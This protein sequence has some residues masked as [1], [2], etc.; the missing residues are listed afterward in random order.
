M[1]LTE[2][3]R[4]GKLE[5]EDISD[6]GNL[7]INNHKFL[8]SIPPTEFP[9]NF[10][11][12][13]ALGAI[14]IISAIILRIS[15]T[16]EDSVTLNIYVSIINFIASAYT[17]LNWPS[18]V[19]STVK[20][21]FRKNSITTFFE[22]KLTR[23]IK[24]AMWAIAILLLFL[25]LLT[26]VVSYIFSIQDVVTDVISILVLGVS[27]LNEKIIELFAKLFENKIYHTGN[28]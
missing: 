18:Q 21:W 15:Y 9:N 5:D 27:I 2:K 24:S 7:Y 4:Y 6:V 26:S 23:K 3:H 25:L 17:F 10:I 12:S 28:I 14:I 8:F 20:N 11:N 16:F 1:H 13:C 22:S 19:T